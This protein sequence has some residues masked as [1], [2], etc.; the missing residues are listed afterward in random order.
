MT[1]FIQPS[2]GAILGLSVGAF[3]FGLTTVL[4]TVAGL[5]Y[6][7]VTSEAA[8][9]QQRKAVKKD[10]ALKEKALNQ[11][12]AATGSFGETTTPQPDPDDT[13]NRL[14][15]GVIGAMVIAVMFV[16]TGKK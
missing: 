4:T 12:F 1:E 11:S 5:A 7:I 6:S 3:I 15:I 8:R 13:G 10:L 2:F 9:D 16:L 14:Q